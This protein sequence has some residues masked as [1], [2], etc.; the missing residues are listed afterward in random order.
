MADALADIRKL[1]GLPQERA[2]QALGRG[3]LDSLAE[4]A[5]RCLDRLHQTAAAPEL[6]ERREAWELLDVLRRPAVLSPRSAVARWPAWPSL[7][8]RLRLRWAAP[9][10][11][12]RSPVVTPPS[13]SALSWPWTWP[14]GREPTEPDGSQRDRHLSLRGTN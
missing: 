4:A 10:A 14:A 13:L 8:E 9:T 2:E 11:R 12:P 3:S 6:G 7:Q 5:Q 1:G